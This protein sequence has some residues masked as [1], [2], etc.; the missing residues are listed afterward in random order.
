M[1]LSAN[2]SASESEKEE[3]K[4]SEEEAESEP[5]P[6]AFNIPCSDEDQGEADEADLAAF[7]K[8]ELRVEKPSR[9]KKKGKPRNAEAV[10]IF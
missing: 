2:C 5:V 9:K 8:H 4:E 7:D 6:D 1:P 3:V 10:E